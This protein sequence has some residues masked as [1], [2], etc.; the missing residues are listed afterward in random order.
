MLVIVDYGMGNLGSLKNMFKAINQQV[1]IESCPKQISLAEKLVLPGVGH[2]DKAMSLF[3]MT[4]GLM[5]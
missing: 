3:N 4:N 2:F 1:S 5:E